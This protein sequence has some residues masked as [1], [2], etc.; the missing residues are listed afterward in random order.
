MRVGKVRR[1]L[2]PL[3]MAILTASC[4][5]IAPGQAVSASGTKAVDK[6]VEGMTMDEKISQMIIPAIRTWNGQDV[7]SLEAHPELKSAL[8]KHQYGGI[9]LFGSNITGN[10]QAAR[11]IYEL[12]LNNARIEGASTH[13]PYLTPVDEEGGRV[14]R[15]STGTRMTGNMALGATPDSTR[16]AEITGQVLGEEIRALGF[17]ADFAPVIDVN[18]NPLNPVIGTR[19]FSDDPALVARLGRAYAKGLGRSKVIATYKHYPG[20]GDTNVDSHIGTPSVQKTYE[21]LKRTELVPFTAAIKNGADMIM[22]AHI[23]YPLIDREVTFGD[24]VTKGYFP[25]TMSHRMITDI[26]RMDMGFKGVVVTDSLEMEA[27]R[28]A[29]LVPGK[30]GS[31]EYS[32]NIAKEVINAGVDILLIPRDLSGPSAAAFFDSYIAGIA[33]KVEAGEISEERIDESVKRILSLKEKY[34]IYDPSNTEGYSADIDKTVAKAKEVVGSAGHHEK[35]MMIAK[36]AIT[37]VKNDDDLLPLSE[38]AANIEFLCQYKTDAA[39]TNYSINEL[40]AKGLISSEATVFVDNYLDSNSNL[41]YSDEMAKR[42]SGA[43]VVIGFSYSDGNNAL[44][45]TDAQYKALKRAISD[46]HAAGGKFILISQNLPY[47]AAVYQDADAIILAY[48]GAGLGIDPTDK[49]ESGQ[50]QLSINA[51]IVAAI[52]TAFGGNTPKGKLSVNIP[53]VLEQADGT[54]SYGTEYLYQRGYGLSW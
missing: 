23:T 33:A 50:G 8:S 5:V 52:Q 37:V 14:L 10:E 7:T 24:G 31:V 19:S 4:M 22:T 13:I 3:I 28:T 42:I 53:K 38:D 17:N 11:L 32:V 30:Q 47:D 9:I 36:A 18:N 26:L 6:V 34:G 12:Q 48:L 16:N 44:D 46:T 54:L 45:K 2:I 21:Q 15:I 43:N 27:I 39:T 35:E 29:G 51:N 20:H 49:N 41:K 40:R 1:I 25:A